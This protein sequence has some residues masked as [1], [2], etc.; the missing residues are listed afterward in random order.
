MN[1]PSIIVRLAGAPIAAIPLTLGGIW[2]IF[3]WTQGR[4]SVWLALLG[5]FVAVR[6]ISSVRQ[7]S[8]YKAW[9]RQ[10]ESVGN[11]GKAPPR[12][13][14]RL[15]RLATIIAAVLF[16]GII[17]FKPSGPSSPEL[18]NALMWLWLLCGTF[19]AA[20]LLIGVGRRVFK[21]RGNNA[22]K[23]KL[24]AVPVSL[25]LSRTVDSPSRE[26]AV[27]NLP[28]YAARMLNRQN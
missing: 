24:E 19:L 10:W 18:Q 15:W 25:M 11:F 22:G 7:R 14:I 8:R 4:A 21:R 3:M 13:P 1:Q 28:E 26:T 5:C 6:T 20:R 23:A 17:A 27:R 9:R 12:R 2:L 16:I